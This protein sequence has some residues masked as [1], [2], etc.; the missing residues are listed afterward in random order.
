MDARLNRHGRNLTCW[1]YTWARVDR[2]TDV[3]ENKGGSSED[4]WRAQ[5]EGRSTDKILISFRLAR[6]ASPNVI[7][8][9]PYITKV[10]WLERGRLMRT[11]GNCD[12]R[13]EGRSVMVRMLRTVAPCRW[14]HVKMLRSLFSYWC[15]RLNV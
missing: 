7:V 15:L 2:D 14:A 9:S 10:L 3:I 13:R 11:K 4:F 8:R 12:I 1:S 6:T 5:V